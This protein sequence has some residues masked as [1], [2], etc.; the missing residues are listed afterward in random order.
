MSRRTPI[1]FPIFRDGKKGESIDDPEYIRYKWEIINTYN[2]IFTLLYG[3]LNIKNNIVDCVVITL[4]NEIVGKFNIDSDI[5]HFKVKSSEKNPKNI[6]HI[7]V[8]TNYNGLGLSKI[9]MKYLV[10]KIKIKYKNDVNDNTILSIVGDASDG[11]WDHIG[12]KGDD[13]YKTITISKLFTKLEENTT[14]DIAE[15]NLE[16]NIIL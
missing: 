12:M 2:E 13:R 1:M 4:G 11:F 15:L 10:D 3:F 8:D 7:Y 5:D 6:M 14:S 16:N 9:L